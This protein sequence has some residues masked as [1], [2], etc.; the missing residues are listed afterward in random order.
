[1]AEHVQRYTTTETI[2][3]V[4]GLQVCVTRIA[5]FE[6]LLATL[7]P[8][9]F[10]EDERL[11]YWAELWPAAVALTQYMTQRLPLAGRRVLELGCG[12][13]LVG[14]VAALQGAHVLS[15]DYEPAALDFAR[16][17]A[18]RNGCT[19]ARFQLMDW[20]QPTLRRRYDYIF[21]SDVI[22]EARNFGPLVALLRRYLA[23][24]G[25]AVFS[26]PGRVNAVPFFALVRQHG[27]TCQTEYWPLAW[28]GNHQIAIHTM[29]Y[30][31][32]QVVRGTALYGRS[33]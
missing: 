25:T 26:E 28:E 5:D 4:Q 23:R 3:E 16:H 2:L 27:L 19:Q 11:P 15:T 1:M 12:L 32:T 33:H 9:T 24:G 8:I 30:Q 17:N 31:E 6:E 7:D 10:A 13:G 14:I 29:R 22:Y 20:R 18:R 21:A